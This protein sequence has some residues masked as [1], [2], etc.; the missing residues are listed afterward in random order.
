MPAGNTCSGHSSGPVLWCMQDVSKHVRLQREH[1][2]KHDQTYTWLE[3]ALT[4]KTIRW[5]KH[6]H[7]SSTHMSSIKCQGL[8]P[9]RV[10]INENKQIVYKMASL[11]PNKP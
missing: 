7:I 9:Q 11:Y 2:N 4:A 8:T 6:Q 10:C 3:I 5:K 1:L